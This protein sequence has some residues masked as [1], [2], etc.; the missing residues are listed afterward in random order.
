[1]TATAMG[2]TRARRVA[3]QAWRWGYFAESAQWM[4]VRCPKCGHHVRAHQGPGQSVIA[5]LDAA[6]I[7]HLPPGGCSAHP[8]PDE[9]PTSPTGST[10]TSGAQQ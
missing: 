9:H 3:R 2:V 1:M 10:D 4:R 5:A 7:S 6:V 8:H